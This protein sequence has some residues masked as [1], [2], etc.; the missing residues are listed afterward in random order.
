MNPETDEVFR[1]TVSEPRDGYFVV[2][3]PVV[4]GMLFASLGLVFTSDSIDLGNVKK[5]MD[6]ELTHWLKRFHV[7]LFVNS[8]DAQGDVIQ[9][10]A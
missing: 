2:Y 6:D 3:F 8:F 1:H 7:P 5:L 4:A 10:K 9:V